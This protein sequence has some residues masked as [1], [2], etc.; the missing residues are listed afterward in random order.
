M[1]SSESMFAAI[2]A[3]A[4][5]LRLA[6]SQQEVLDDPEAARLEDIT[7][8]RGFLVLNPELDLSAFPD[9]GVHGRVIERDGVEYRVVVDEKLR[10]MTD[11][12]TGEMRQGYWVAPMDFVYLNN[13]RP[14]TMSDVEFKAVT[15]TEP[16][17][18][19][20]P[21][22]PTGRCTCAGEGTCPWCERRGVDE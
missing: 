2:L 15:L 7:Q 22:H 14:G 6:G 16:L 19:D 10:G 21:M 8:N 13:Y 12:K 17:I 11:S 1:T 5:D 4:Q 20:D 9:P 3:A 18:S